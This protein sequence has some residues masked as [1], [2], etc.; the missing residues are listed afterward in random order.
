MIVSKYVQVEKKMMTRKTK[1][2]HQT[3]TQKM[4]QNQRKYV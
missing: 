2:Q 3:K 4:Q 1:K